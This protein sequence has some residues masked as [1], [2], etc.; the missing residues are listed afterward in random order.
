NMSLKSIRVERVH[1]PENMRIDLT[2][3]E[4]QLCT[5]LDE[6]TASLREKHNITTTCRIAG[7]WVRDKVS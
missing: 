4:G 6:C 1:V 7:G 3:E 2:P 5:L